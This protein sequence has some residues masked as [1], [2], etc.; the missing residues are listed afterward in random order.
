VKFVVDAQLPRRLSHWL[1][2]VGHDAVHTL[3]LPHGNNTTDAE[4]LALARDEQRVVVTKDTDFLD[5]WLL[6]NRPEKLLLVT[7]GNITNNDLLALFERNLH[8]ICA[9]LAAN[10]ALELNSH[11][12]LVRG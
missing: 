5:T 12:V 6:Q 2:S 11:D 9:L 4:I 10:S 7:T 1:K 8:T 3:D